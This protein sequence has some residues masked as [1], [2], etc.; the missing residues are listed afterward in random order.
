[1]KEWYLYV[2]LCADG[3]Y[4]TGVTTDTK[5]RL[6]EHN[7]TK[8]GAKYTKTRRPVSL[9][10]VDKH[11]DRSSAQKAEYNFKQLTRK[12]KDEYITFRAENR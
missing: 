12:Q 7:T 4:Y 1:M 11:A 3:S 6:Y 10:Y 5:R 9:I 8:R 2:L